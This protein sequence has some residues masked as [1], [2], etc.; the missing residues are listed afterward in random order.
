MVSA[1]LIMFCLAAEGCHFVLVGSRRL[2]T[3]NQVAVLE[4]VDSITREFE[5]RAETV[6]FIA[7]DG[8]DIN[9]LYLIMQFCYF[10]ILI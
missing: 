10:D 7:I 3:E 1:V 5:D 4:E 8:T 6:V 9:L 2:M